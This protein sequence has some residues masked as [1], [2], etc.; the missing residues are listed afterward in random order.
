M[1]GVTQSAA[2]ASHTV[3]VTV[4]GS[5]VAL[6]GSEPLLSALREHLGL[7]GAK[8]GCG[9]GACGACTVLI[10]GEPAQSCRR[11]V[12]SA[13]GRSVTTIEGL[14]SQPLTGD[15]TPGRR[16]HP[17]Q[18]AFA[19]H[20]A[21]QCGFCTPGMI[22]A[23]A[24]MLEANPDPDDAAID[25]A[26]AGQ[27]CRC[28]TYQR[29]RHAVRDL[30]EV[31]RRGI[32][33]DADPAGYPADPDADRWGPVL[34]EGSGYRPERPWDLTAPLERDWFGALGDG[35]VVVAAPLPPG[36]GAWTASGGAWLHLAADGGVVAFTGK[37]DVGQD[38]RTALRQLVAEELGV[39]LASVRIA[40]GDTDLC[41]YD[42]GT[43]GSRSM[44]DAGSELRRAA[45]FARGLLPIRPGERR[46][47]VMTGPADLSDPAGW[48]VAGQPHRAPGT[49]AA[50]TGTRRFGSDLQCPGMLHG[51]VL[52][53]PVPGSVLRSLD[54][55]AA[56]SGA[57]RA[58]VVRADGMTGVVAPD[59]AAARAVLADLRAKAVWDVPDAPSDTSITSYLR[60]HPGPDQ[61]GR[62]GGRFLHQEG[63]APTALE[64]AVI[65]CEATYTTAYIA[66]AALETRVAL[67]RWDGGR[68]T[69]W[70]GTQKPFGVRSEVAAALGVADEDVRIIV[71]ATGGA[72]GGKHASQVAIEAAVL[73][74]E[75]DAPVRV[76]WSRWEEFAAGTLRPAAVIDIS[77]GLTADGRLAGWTHRNINSGAA[78]IGSPYRVAD[79]R[80]EYQPASS[81]LPQAS[82]RALAA[83][84]NNFARESMI[85]ELALAAGADPVEFRLANLDDE[86]LAD[87]LRAVAAHV[88]W[89]AGREPISGA[90]VGIACGLEKDARVVTAAQVVIGRDRTVRVA[91]LVTGY[92]CGAIVN[93]ATVTSQIEGATIMAFG[94]AMFEAIRFAGGQISNAAFSAYRVP[95]MSDIPP[96]EVLLMNR[97][98]LPPAGAG[99][100]PMIAV[101]PAIAA[102]IFEAT[103]RRL[104]SLPLVPDG[105]LP[106]K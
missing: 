35:L 92:D 65:R 29:I 49:V 45:A 39:P 59:P 104:R 52:R 66:A 53:P 21:A 76:A 96:I 101:A 54:L 7:I 61:P 8:F 97:P 19:D 13:A 48:R 16:L 55:E 57:Q 85:D 26:L 14:S 81:P 42:M 46:L 84:A 24:A 9:E 78:G 100:T 80:L 23:T 41:P 37:V 64:S 79:Q 15:E 69:V 50:V 30:A 33:A 105:V 11:S 34:P 98:D 106:A 91:H 87:V 73:A 82:Y 67:A 44:P 32:G 88:G 99:E 83:T 40:M 86:R 27:V 62:W 56:G 72:F 10:D 17:V 94:G 22:L 75:A 4:N 20:G 95:R 1:T 6:P 36:S 68:L 28:G 70:T 58:R 43:F 90:G 102:A 18:R 77:A 47:E 2:P 31:T 51:V 74:R 3:T 63:S 60:S 38:N 93:P 5:D 12:E 89:E 25:A 71:P 103:G